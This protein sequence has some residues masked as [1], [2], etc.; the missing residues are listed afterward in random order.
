M[1][2]QI[3]V[4][5]ACKDVL[6]DHLAVAHGPELVD[7]G[8]LT[9]RATLDNTLARVVVAVG[10]RAA[11]VRDR[12]DAVFLIPDNRAAGA[13]RDM[14]PTRLVAAQIVVISAIPDQ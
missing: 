13:V 5:R 14:I 2:V 6:G 10:L 8:R 11:I 4:G 9:L 3:N 7:V 12:L 1:K